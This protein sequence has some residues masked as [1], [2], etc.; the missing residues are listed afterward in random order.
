MHFR[1]RNNPPPLLPNAE[2]NDHAIPMQIGVQ[3]AVLPPA[4]QVIMQ[5]N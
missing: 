2:M 5:G 4:N 1:I 3:G